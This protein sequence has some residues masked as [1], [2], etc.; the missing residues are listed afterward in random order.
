MMYSDGLTDMVSDTTIAAEF[1][2]SE[3][4]VTAGLGHGRHRQRCRRTG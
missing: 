2:R 3:D 4:L 1:S